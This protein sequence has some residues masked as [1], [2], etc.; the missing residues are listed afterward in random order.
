MAVAS[1]LAGS[2]KSL[3]DPQERI[4]SGQ[5]WEESPRVG[6]SLR[7]AGTKPSPWIV[8][9][10]PARAGALR[11]LKLLLVHTMR[12]IHPPVSPAHDGVGVS[13]AALRADEPTANFR[14]DRVAG[15]SSRWRKRNTV[16]SSGTGSRPKQ[17][18]F[19]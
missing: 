7:P 15:A 13:T 2:V 1:A 4:R 5:A 8:I 6:N 9:P 3:L 19:L 17:T 12:Q 18:P 10:S 14:H 16:V 11:P